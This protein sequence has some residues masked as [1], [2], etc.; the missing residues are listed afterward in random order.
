MGENSEACSS[1]QSDAQREGKTSAC[2]V[3]WVKGEKDGCLGDELGAVRVHEQEKGMMA[4]QLKNERGEG[5][6]HEDSE[7]SVDA[8]VLAV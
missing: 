4:E 8:S 5:L 1:Q 6:T 2:W 3:V 7:L